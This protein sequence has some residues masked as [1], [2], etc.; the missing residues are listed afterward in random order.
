M[1]AL[2]SLIPFYIFIATLMPGRT[3]HVPALWDRATG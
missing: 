1:I 2:V 3:L